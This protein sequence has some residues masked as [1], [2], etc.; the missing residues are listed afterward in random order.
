MKYIVVVGCSENDVQFLSGGAHSL[1]V[2]AQVA[3][4]SIL[5]GA[6]FWDMATS[7]NVL[8][9]KAFVYE[10]VAEAIVNVEVQFSQR[11]Q[12]FGKTEAVSA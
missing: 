8:I 7:Q 6:R 5:S 10:L 2:A 9:T 4:E 12:N 3:K 1:E 11:N